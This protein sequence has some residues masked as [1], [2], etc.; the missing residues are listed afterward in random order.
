[1]PVGSF[2]M[3]SMPSSTP[4]A[5]QQQQGLGQQQTGGAALYEPT[6][7][8]GG[9]PSYAPHWLPAIGQPQQLR[10]PA[11]LSIPVDV[12][13]PQHVQPPQHAQPLQQQSFS[14]AGGLR[15]ASESLACQERGTCWEC[16]EA[17]ARVQA[18]D[19]VPSKA[20]RPTL[21]M[22]RWLMSEVLRGLLPR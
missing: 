11:V 17:R 22:F 16:V 5:V 12:R 7:F 6:M 20:A 19:T 13:L 10:S 3:P 9:V 8:P 14:D 21:R 2:G 18:K 15:R 1:M 4:M